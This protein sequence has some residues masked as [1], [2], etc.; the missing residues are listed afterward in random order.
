MEND[1]V[2]T[3]IF[4]GMWSIHLEMRKKEKRTTKIFMFFAFCIIGAMRITATCLFSFRHFT[5]GFACLPACTSSQTQLPTRN[6]LV[7]LFLMSSTV[8]SSVQLMCFENIFMECFSFC[9]HSIWRLNWNE[10]RKQHCNDKMNGT[11]ANKWGA[12]DEEKL[13]KTSSWMCVYVCIG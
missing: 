1:V 10:G 7:F 9:V 2:L 6:E 8:F 12:L 13:D 4:F 5:L 11:F 3:S